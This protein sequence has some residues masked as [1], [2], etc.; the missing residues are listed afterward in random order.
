MDARALTEIEALVEV[1][2][3][4]T[5]AG[6]AKA[7]KVSASALSRT[8][9]RLEE[10]LGARLLQ[11]TTRSLSLTE[12]GEK[13]RR[14]GVALLDDLRLAEEEARTRETELAGTLRVSAPT[15][16]GQ[17]VVVNAVSRLCS[18]YPA[19]NIELEL[20]D[21]N[22]DLARERVDV[23]VRLG[24]SLTSSSLRAHKVGVQEHALVGTPELLSRFPAVRRPED[25]AQLPG[26]ELFHAKQRGVWR[27]LGENGEHKVSFN[28]RVETNNYAALIGLVRA[29]SGV[30]AVPSYLVQAELAD[31][32]LARLLPRF[33][34]PRRNIW[35]VHTRGGARSAVIRAFRDELSRALRTTHAE[36]MR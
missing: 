32:R 15:L 28:V 2:H 6:A 11:R 22:V 29:G 26:V 13:L 30:G 18:N 36:V 17:S 24:E 9:S 12:A 33:A 23:A 19:V 16:F 8:L 27:L 14:R 20:S 35:L 3:A 1:A 34:L 25:L 5:I 31:G 7:L 10:R 21:Q 4:G